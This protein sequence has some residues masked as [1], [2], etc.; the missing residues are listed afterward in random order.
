MLRDTPKRIRTDVAP[1]VA[2][3][4]A[5]KEEVARALR[6]AAGMLDGP[7]RLDWDVQAGAKK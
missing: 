2:A 7:D 5:T 6:D 1:A 4:G 3:T